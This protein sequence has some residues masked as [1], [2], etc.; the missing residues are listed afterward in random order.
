VS[1]AYLP[2]TEAVRDRA[3]AYLA[4]M[5]ARGFEPPP[6]GEVVR[7]VEAAHVVDCGRCYGNGCLSCGYR[8]TVETDAGREAREEAEDRRADER[9][10]EP[11]DSG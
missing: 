6:M 2:V 4:A 1:G 7:M 11:R 9:R 3:N 8:G 10:H 5:A